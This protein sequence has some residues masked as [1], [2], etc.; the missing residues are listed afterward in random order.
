MQPII[1]LTDCIATGSGE[2][3]WLVFAISYG[4]VLQ[5]EYVAGFSH[6]N[7]MAVE[8]CERRCDYP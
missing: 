7:L 4:K 5:E 6:K 2:A 8:A 1:V 3:A